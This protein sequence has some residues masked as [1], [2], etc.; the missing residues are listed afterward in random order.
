MSWITFAIGSP[1][2]HATKRRIAIVTAR[3]MERSYLDRV[4]NFPVRKWWVWWFCNLGA[5]AVFAAPLAQS[6]IAPAIAIAQVSSEVRAA[7]TREYE[8]EVTVRPHSGD[9]WTR[10]A[11]RITG[12]ASNWE[13]LA[14][15]NQA[16]EQHDRQYSMLCLFGVL[17]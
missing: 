6:P 2:L 10:L 15:L 4:Y 14:S 7:L 16:V 1:F 12:D 13:D 9:A 11:K 5:A 8:I 17:R 3:R